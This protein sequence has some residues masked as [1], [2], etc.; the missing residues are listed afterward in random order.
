MARSKL[1][2]PRCIST[3]VTATGSEESDSDDGPGTQN[4]AEMDPPAPKKKKVEIAPD[5]VPSADLEEYDCE[6]DEDTEKTKKEVVADAVQSASL[7]EYDCETD[8]DTISQLNERISDLEQDN[9][10]GKTVPYLP[11]RSVTHEVEKH[12]KR[13]VTL[14]NNPSWTQRRCSC[15]KCREM[16]QEY[17]NDPNSIYPTGAEGQPT[18]TISNPK[19]TGG[20][21]STRD[22]RIKQI[23]FRAAEA[24]GVANAG[25]R[26]SIY[27]SVVHYTQWSIESY[28]NDPS[29]NKSRFQHYL[30]PYKNSNGDYTDEDRF[31]CVGTTK[32]TVQCL[33]NAKLGRSCVCNKFFINTPKMV[34]K[35]EDSSSRKGR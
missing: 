19:N 17:L 15:G 26:K 28:N 32:Q 21:Q 23:Y 6:T 7:N 34:I 2:V 13:M 35:K 16:V 27:V 10:S 20:K 12:G 31:N 5:A 1:S 9:S 14:L 30:I 24:I 29:K 8:D 33:N 11:L 22:E 3:G 25:K 4:L 18:F